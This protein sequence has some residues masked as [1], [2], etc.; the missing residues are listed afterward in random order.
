MCGA[1]SEIQT[2]SS[3]SIVLTSTLFL[4]PPG[5]FLSHQDE[6]AEESSYII[7]PPSRI[8][9]SDFALSKSSFDV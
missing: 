2:A 8:H 1:F 9:I 6:N 4:I 7:L 3:Y 5:D